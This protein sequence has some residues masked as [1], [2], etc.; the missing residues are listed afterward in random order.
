MKK[1]SKHKKGTKHTTYQ[2][3]GQ[4]PR[5]PDTIHLS[6]AHGTWPTS[7]YLAEIKTDKD[8]YTETV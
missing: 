6:G 5:A 1:I 7:L 8:S 4:E 2:L 3:V